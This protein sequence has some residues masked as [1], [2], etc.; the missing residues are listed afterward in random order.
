MKLL[1]PLKDQGIQSSVQLEEGTGE[2]G[3]HRSMRVH[4]N[5]IEK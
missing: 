2:H 5:Q 3:A 4:I 1:E